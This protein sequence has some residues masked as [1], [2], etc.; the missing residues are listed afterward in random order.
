MVLVAGQQ[1]ILPGRVLKPD[2][3]V[4]TLRKEEIPHLG[5]DIEEA[6]LGVEE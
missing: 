3:R 1:K 5:E 2:R 6:G 4:D